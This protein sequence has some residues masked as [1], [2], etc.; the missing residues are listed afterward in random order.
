VDGGRE[1]LGHGDRGGEL[2]EALLGLAAQLGG[3]VRCGLVVA[4][5]HAPPATASP[6]SRFAP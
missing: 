6:P 5:V 2:V 1:L 4:L 3:G